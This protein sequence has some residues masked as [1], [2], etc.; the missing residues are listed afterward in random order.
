MFRFLFKAATLLLLVAVL[1]VAA[2]FGINATDEALSADAQALQDAAKP[3]EPSERNGFIDFL[4]LGAPAGVSVQEVGLAQLRA[5]NTSGGGG[6]PGVKIEQRIL[7]CAKGAVLDCAATLARD[8]PL[9]AQLGAYA[10]FLERYRAMRAKPEFVD[11]L[12]APSPSDPLPAYQELV[13]GNRLALLIAAD[14]FLAGDRAAA[15]DELEAEYAFYRRVSAGARTLLPKMIAFAMLD[16]SALFAA[17]LARR[18]PVED[19]ASFVRLDA[20]LRP[21]SAA[22]LDM[23][24]T[25]ETELGEKVGWMR[26]RK[27]VRLSDAEYEVFANFGDKR[28][29][30]WW[31]PLAPYLY[32]P[33][34]S[35]NHFVAQSRVLQRVTTEPATRFHAAVEERRAEVQAMQPGFAGLLF[36]P[37]G[38]FN[39]HLALHDLTDYVGRA[40]AHGGFQSLVRLQVRLRAAGT[41]KTADVAAALAGPLGREHVD[42]FTGKTVEF[43]T[44]RGT[45]GFAVRE[46]LL[47]SV[48]RTGA[49]Y[50]GDRLA[51]PL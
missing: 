37:A 32:R 23:K 47:S 36:S 48:L 3:P 31:D 1:A 20:M 42:P 16:R 45:I 51:L 34:Q 18:I 50:A 7:D 13:Y 44:A 27:H 43:D 8:K 49:F 38:Y 24:R 39:Y 21:P 22:E 17:E 14:R 10:L 28:G 29:R 41:S 15:L 35:V 9:A 12:A 2:L 33:H 6:L 4:A 46:M 5:Y 19:K 25:W 11:L 30:P 40:H 26:T